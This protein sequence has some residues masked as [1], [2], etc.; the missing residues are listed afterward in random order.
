MTLKRKIA[1]M[2]VGAGIAPLVLVVLPAG[3]ASAHGYISSPASRQAQCATGVVS[4]CGQI[5][6]EPQSVEG[7]K[8]LKNCSANI[9]Q[10]AVLDDANK[11]WKATSVGSTVDFNWVLT[12]RHA[13]ST[14]EYFVGDTKI[15]SFDDGGKQPGATVKHTVSLGGRTGRQTVRA[16]WNIADTPMAFYSCVDLQVGGGATNPPTTTNPPATT[17]TTRPPATTTTTSRTNPPAS[18][19]WAPNTA[20]ATGSTTTYNGASYRCIQGH[21]SLTGWEPAATPALWQKL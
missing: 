2:A 4:G 17:T 3:P 5:Q 19:A 21:T 18:G 20:Y 8:G 1:A 7:P 16:V 13:T 6:Y 11:G 12:A 15:A 9:G 10:F 14:W